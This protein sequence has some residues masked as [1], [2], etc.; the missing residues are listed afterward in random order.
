MGEPAGA[1]P[2]PAEL[3]EAPAES[4]RR[5]KVVAVRLYPAE[6]DAWAAAAAAEGRAEVGRWVRERV[7]ASLSGPAARGPSRAEAVAEVM[8]ARAEL[9]RIGNNVNQAVRYAH[10][11]AVGGREQSDAVEQLA[12]AIE[13]VVRELRSVREQLEGVGL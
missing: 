2:L 3:V 8:R 4:G 5:A 12:V 9:A 10:G 1:G 11:V 7:G 6:W 13:G